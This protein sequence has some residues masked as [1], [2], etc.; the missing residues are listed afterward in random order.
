MANPNVANACG[1][2]DKFGFGEVNFGTKHMSDLM[3]TQAEWAKGILDADRLPVENARVLNP[4]NSRNNTYGALVQGLAVRN[5]GWQS[6]DPTVKATL[7]KWIENLNT[8]F[9]A[10]QKYE[11]K[12]LQQWATDLT[13]AAD[14]LSKQTTTLA[15][16]A[17]ITDTDLNY[18]NTIIDGL[19]SLAANLGELH[20]AVKAGPDICEVV[21]DW[22]PQQH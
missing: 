9:T 2:E 12:D 3:N 15:Q 6:A 21:L 20:K 5:R 4:A 17:E 19:K 10:H 11:P 18:F 16:R 13:A 22:A 7:S 1:C 8:V 14:C